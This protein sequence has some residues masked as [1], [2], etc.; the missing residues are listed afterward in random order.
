[1]HAARAIDGPPTFAPETVE[2]DTPA[3]PTSIV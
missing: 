1:M 3:W 2:F